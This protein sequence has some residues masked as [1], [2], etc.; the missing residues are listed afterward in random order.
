[1]GKLTAKY[2]ENVTE[3]GTYE[4]GE[5]LRLIVK[6]TGRKNWVLRFQLHGKRREMG[7]G[8]YP[9]F[10]LKRPARPPMKTKSRSSAV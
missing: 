8:G 1:M 5:R 2:V 7:L 4:D 9:Q 6:A 3:P 10:D